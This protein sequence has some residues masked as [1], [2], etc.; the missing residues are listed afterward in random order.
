MEDIILAQLIE[1]DEY[2]RKV[3][4]YL[5]PELFY[6]EAEQNIFTIIS[7][8]IEKYNTLPTKEVLY[9]EVQGLDTLNETTFKETMELV[10][11]LET[12][13]TTSSVWLL[14]QTEE[15]IQTRSIH[16]AIRQSIKILDNNTE[17]SFNAIPELL[18]EALAI[19]FD[20]HV[21]HDFIADAESRYESYHT[22]EDKIPFNIDY[23]NRVT[24]GGT[25]KKTLNVILA[26]TGVGKSL[27]MC[28]MAS[29][30]LLDNKNVLYITLEMAEER[31]A[32]RIDANLLD[33]TMSELLELS[34]TDYDNRIT[35]LK[36]TTKGRLIIK[37]Y[38]TASAGAGHFRHLLNELR[39]KKN[40]VPDI[41]YIDYINLCVSSRIRGNAVVNSYTYIKAISEELRG[42]GV[43]FNLPIWTATQTNRDGIGSSDLDLNDTSDS[44]GLPMTVDFMVALIETPELEEQGQMMFKQLKNRYGDPGVNKF[45]VVAV[46]KSK[47][48]IYDASMESQK[49][50]MDGPVMDSTDFGQADSSRGKKFDKTKFGEF[51]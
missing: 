41:V 40:F 4:P 30:N 5:T 13:P 15:F 33:V 43:E 11:G 32:Q 3:I 2:A 6:S 39:I 34:K 25:P 18:T 35:R 31:I 1:N 23:L 51:Q 38:P 14:D 20:A 28:S 36:D 27:A 49:D 46:N 42:L 45:F 8:H 7:G 26:P 29:G 17:L 37:E 50:I 21:G 12:D 24:G 44:I 47:M 22:L 9:T 19:S 48:R 16:N 10:Q